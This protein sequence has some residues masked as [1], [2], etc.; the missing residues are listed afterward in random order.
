ME[1]WPSYDI[2]YSHM[3]R[4]SSR[5][6]RG[7]DIAKNRTK[8]APRKLEETF[9]DAAAVHV[10]GSY[11]EAFAEVRPYVQQSKKEFSTPLTFNWSGGWLFF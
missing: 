9:A 6:V 5:S 8:M 7:S 11:A 4:G 1:S 10:R 2:S 3:L